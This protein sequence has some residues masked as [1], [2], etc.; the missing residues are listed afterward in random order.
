MSKAKV[1][2]VSKRISERPVVEKSTE[3]E[4]VARLVVANSRSPSNQFIA[5]GA[6]L[7]NGRVALRGEFERLLVKA[8][9]KQIKQ[10]ATKQK[11]VEKQKKGAEAVLAATQ[12]F[13]FADL[14]PR[15]AHA[16]ATHSPTQP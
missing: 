1:V 3:D 7:M 15:T 6:K 2:K 8:K 12:P 5:V 11:W 10:D 9:E 4:L 16:G 14:M 13:V